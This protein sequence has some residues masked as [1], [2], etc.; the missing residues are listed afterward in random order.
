[1]E[2]AEWIMCGILAGLTAHDIKTK[3]VPVAAVVV[4]AVG[5]LIYRLFEGVSLGTL[6]AGL[7]P[8][9]VVLVLSYATEED[10]G[11]G[12][13]LVLCMLGVFC[14]W[15][16]C[17]A[18]FGMALMLSGILAVIL[19]VCRRVGRKTELPFLPGLVLGYLLVYL[20]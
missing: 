16:R 20:W 1:M 19:L 15:R 11:L 12:D 7:V 9:I 18:V 2:T 6:M 5:A 13:G 3:T 17:L 8:G 10:I 4:V 14:G